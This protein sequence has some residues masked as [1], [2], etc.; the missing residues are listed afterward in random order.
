MLGVRVTTVAVW[1]RDGRRLTPWITPGGHRRFQLSDVRCLLAEL[2]SAVDAALI[3]D[4]VR[5]YEQS[6]STRKVAEK[7]GLSYGRTRRLLVRHTT[8]RPKGWPPP[9]PPLTNLTDQPGA[10]ARQPPPG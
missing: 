4:A 1:A 7:L 10:P 5:L 9:A 8:L 3:E 2:T 6:W